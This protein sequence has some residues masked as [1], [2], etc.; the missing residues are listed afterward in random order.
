M[1]SVNIVAFMQRGKSIFVR[2]GDCM[3]FF[4]GFLIGNIVGIFLWELGR[5]AIKKIRELGGTKS[6]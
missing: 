5:V 3:N 2:G 1:K 4:I 6:E